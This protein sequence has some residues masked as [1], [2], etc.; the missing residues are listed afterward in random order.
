MDEM[1]QKKIIVLM[2]GPSAEGDVSRRTG[3][4]ILAALQKKGY[5]AEGMELEPA[6]LMADLKAASCDIVFIAIHGKFGEDGAVQGA[7]EMMGIPYT[8]S[9]VMASA[10]AMDK[11]ATKDMFIA[12]GVPT[13]RS[14]FYDARQDQDEIE[15]AIRADFGVPVVIK[16][17]AQ[18]SSIGVT[19]VT[20]D[21]D[22]KAAI[23]EGF[24]YSEGILVEQYVKG[25]E[26]TVAVW[27]DGAK[28]KALPV[29]EIR[30]HSG[31]Y[32]YT[33]KYTS[34]ATDYLCPAP[35]TEEETHIVQ[36]AAVKAFR[37]L[38]CGGIAR[39]DVLLDEAGRPY[40]LE[41]NTIPGMTATSLVPK[42]AAAAGIS[43]EDLCEKIL[44][45][46]VR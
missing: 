12:H 33:S 42:A 25:R 45:S 23:E 14:V 30:P 20:E 27:D 15:T 43:F 1:K 29:V 6:T 7:L 5:Q 17:V 24:R 4:A 44:L 26:L 18:G 32:D 19:I 37:S 11:A 8:G 28:T 3:A 46:A 36:D 41:V 9:G 35:L 22:L 10:V 39:A 31:A 16:S 34:G 40:V 38:R 2:G 13:P 21:D